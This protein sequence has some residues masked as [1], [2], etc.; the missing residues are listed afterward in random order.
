M[1]VMLCLCSVSA[2]QFRQFAGDLL[3]F[4]S[5]DLLS[6]LCSSNEH[7]FPLFVPLYIT[8]FTSSIVITV[9]RKNI[10]SLQSW[11]T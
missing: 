10:I 2:G 9:N 1:N 5:F 4:A 3:V 6:C 11:F 7:M 8:C